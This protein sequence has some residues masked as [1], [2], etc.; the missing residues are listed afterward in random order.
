MRASIQAMKNRIL[1]STMLLSCLLQ[2]ARGEID[3]DPGMHPE[4]APGLHNKN[5]AAESER[6]RKEIEK[7]KTRRERNNEHQGAEDDAISP[8]KRNATYWRSKQITAKPFQRPFSKETLAEI[9]K[10]VHDICRALNHCTES[11]QDEKHISVLKAHANAARTDNEELRTK[12][13]RTSELLAID[14]KTTKIDQLRD[15]LNVLHWRINGTGIDDHPDPVYK[16]PGKQPLNGDMPLP[17][18]PFGKPVHV[19]PESI[20][21]N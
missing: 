20:H 11:D 12:A 15:R 6:R 17:V 14:D 7:L 21:T 18:L 3:N 10:E 16:S 8:P 19:A 5:L 9:H 1:I 4:I 13:K 2:P